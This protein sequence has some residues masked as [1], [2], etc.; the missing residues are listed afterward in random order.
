MRAWQSTTLAACRA[1]FSAGSRTP[2]NKAIMPITTSNSTSVKA[3]R[4]L[5]CR[6]SCADITA[7]SGLVPC[8]NRCVYAESRHGLRECI[9]QTRDLLRT[10]W[11]VTCAHTFEPGSRLDRLWRAA[12]TVGT[13]D[14]HHLFN[15]SKVT[16]LCPSLVA[17]LLKLS[18]VD[19]GLRR[20]FAGDHQLSGLGCKAFYE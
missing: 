4:W 10:A 19:P 9:F 17:G 13:F 11:A 7:S 12:G 20:A 8:P 5:C 16:G 18:A 15:R 6:Q 1:L 3:R 2:I 14:V